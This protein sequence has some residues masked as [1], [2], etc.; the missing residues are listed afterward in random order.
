MIFFY[1]FHKYIFQYGDTGTSPTYS[2]TP[3]IWKLSKYVILFSTCTYIIA[4]NKIRLKFVLN[5]WILIFLMSFNLLALIFYFLRS[6]EV[7]F[8]ELE[9]IV[10]FI[11]Y[12]ILLA[13]DEKLII[14]IANYF[15]EN[16]KLIIGI[17]FLGNVFAISNYL[18]FG[19]LP[20]LA[21]E[22]ILV[23][24]GGLWDDPNGFGFLCS[25]F[26]AMAYKNKWWIILIGLVVSICLTFSISSFINFLF[27][28]LFFNF[29]NQ[30]LDFSA[31][32]QGSIEQHTDFGNTAFSLFAP[33]TNKYV[34]YETWL[35]G[36]FVNYTPISLFGLF[37]IFFYWIK[38]ILSNDRSFFSIYIIVFIF[39]NLFIPLIEDFP[40][41][42][43]F[44]IFLAVDQRLKRI[45]FEE[46]FNN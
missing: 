7:I 19:R 43:L 25:V 36:Y 21:F 44:F 28:L 14:E 29:N 35:F 27:I 10:W 34:K 26:T 12:L 16:I 17:L 11:L 31:L 6:G 22:G 30:I 18:I 3:V 15:D 20:A 32:K 5:N 37:L 9:Y 41:S 4:V 2:D 33:L 38:K 45:Q 1:N 23:R 13:V 46:S 42:L 24:F 8:E 39:G 40:I